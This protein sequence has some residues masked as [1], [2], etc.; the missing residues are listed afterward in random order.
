MRI[1]DAP[2]VTANKAHLRGA[3]RQVLR[4]YLWELSIQL[5]DTQ[6]EG[7]GMSPS[8]W[9]VFVVSRGGQG[10]L[11]SLFADGQAED[12]ETRC[13]PRVTELKPVC[14]K[15]KGLTQTLTFC[16]P[17]SWRIPEE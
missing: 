3:Q 9:V 17:P 16:L 14:D 12:R 5:Q 8:I 1:Y 11:L 10:F 13:I 6:N 4:T 7:A 15:D 2:K